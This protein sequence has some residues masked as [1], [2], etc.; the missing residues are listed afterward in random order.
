MVDDRDHPSDCAMPLCLPGDQWTSDL[1]CD[2]AFLI[3]KQGS[4]QITKRRPI[5]TLYLSLL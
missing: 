3:L 4:S 1:Q 2:R 5:K